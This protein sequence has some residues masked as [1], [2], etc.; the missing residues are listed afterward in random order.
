MPAVQSLRAGTVAQMLPLIAGYTVNLLATP[1]I[2]AKLGF[3]NFGAWSLTGAIAQYAALFDLGVTR[4]TS[5]YVAVYHSREDKDGERAVLGLTVIVL[6]GLSAVLYLVGYFSAPLVERL[7]RTGSEDL[8][9][10]LVLSATS[11]LVFGMTARA[12]AGAANGRGRQVPANIGISILTVSQILFGATA[13]VFDPSLYAFALWS[14]V[15]AFFGMVS[16]LVITTV[17]EGRVHFG[18]PS[19]SLAREFVAYGVKGQVLGASD[20]VL[21]QSGKLLVGIFVGPAAAGAYELGSRLIQGAQAFGSATSVALA[22]YLT[23]SYSVE[24]LASIRKEYRRLTQRN[25]VVAIL[26]AML[27]GATAMTSIPLWLGE[28]SLPVIGVVMG[29]AIGTALNAATGVCSATLFSLGRAGTIG[30]VAAVNAFI[31]I[32]IAIPVTRLWGLAGTV[33]AYGGWLILGTLLGARWLHAQLDIP[34]REFT[35]AIR[36][37]FVVSLF[38]AVPAV[39]LGVVTSPTTRSSAI[40]PFML[41]CVAYL[42]IYVWLAQRLGY[43]SVPK[44]R[45]I[46]DVIG[47][48]RHVASG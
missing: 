5:R 15:G 13:L 32:A 16:V 33:V 40:V 12:F 34:F 9:R 46:L 29:L 36:G 3:H 23:R 20:V 48:Q 7:I 24:G 10:A 35:H 42:A 1:F 45:R 43:V 47:R 26:P 18:W 14:A 11:M 31:A 27:L 6:I 2:V 44:P 38:A 8:A 22:T 39:A 21:F 17:D 19:G 30:L 4:A 37:P 28:R 25:A 41:A